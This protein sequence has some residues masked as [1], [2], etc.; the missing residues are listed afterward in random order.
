MLLKEGAAVMVEDRWKVLAMSG[1][2]Q[3]VVQSQWDW[4]QF[5]P[6]I[7]LLLKEQQKVRLDM[8]S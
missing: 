8:C 4:G 2:S 3:A 6:K 7:I 5:V 1:W